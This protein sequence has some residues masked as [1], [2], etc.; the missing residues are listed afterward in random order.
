M[1][2]QNRI[3]SIYNVDAIAAEHSAVTDLVKKSIEQIEAARAKSIDFNINTKTF[4]DYNKKVKEL[5]KSLNVM[6]KATR[7]A[8]AGSTA[9]AKQKEAEAKAQL[10]NTRATTAATKETERQTASAKKAAAAASQNEREYK[11][12]SAAYKV[13]KERAEDLGAKYGVLDKRAKAAAKEAEGLNDK[14]KAIDK[15]I[16]NHQRNVGNYSSALEGVGG[17]IKGLTTNFLALLGVVGVGDFFKGAIDE[18]L[19]MDRNVRLLQNTL[20][21]IGMPEAFDR[22]SA[23]ADKLAKQFGYLDNDDVLKSFQQLITYGKLTEDQMNELLPVIIDFAAATGQGIPEATST[24]IKVLEGNGKALK[25]YGINIKDAKNTT[26]AFGIVMTE[27]AP[28]V[29][30]VGKTFGD[31]AAG[32]LAASQQRFKDL[33]EEIGSGLLPVL[34][35]VLSVLVDIAK[36]AFGAGKAVSEALGGEKSFTAAVLENSDNKDIAFES[37]QVFNT[38]MSIYKEQQKQLADRQKEGKLLDKTQDDLQKDFTT[39]LRARLS[40]RQKVY[41]QLKKSGFREGIMTT[42]ADIRGIERALKEIETVNK[43]IEA[44][45]DPN[46]LFKEGGD[47]KDKKTKAD[48]SAFDILKANIELDKEF[49]ARRLENDKLSYQDRLQALIDYGNDSRRL[50]EEQAKQDLKNSELTAGERIKI[51]NDKNN[52]LIRLSQELADKLAKITARDFK[53]DTSKI[54]S[55]AGNLPKEIQ[56]A[57]DDYKK[58]QDDAIKKHEE[59][60]KEL[61]KNTHEAIKELASELQGLFFDI[62]T[63]AIER[64]K[65]AVQDQIDLLEAQKQKDIEVANQTITNAQERADA[66]AVIEARASAKRQQLELKQRQLDQQKAKFEKARLVAEIVQTT[67]LAVVKALTQADKLGPGAIALAAVIGALG[68]VQIARVLAQPIP[69][70]KDGT[71]NHPGGL[72]VVGDGGRSEGVILP[73]GSVYKTPATDTVVNLPKGSKVVPDYADMKKPAVYVD[74]VDTT[75]ELRKGFGQVV[76]AVRRI[77]QPIIQAEKAWTVAH[78]QGSNFRNYLNR[79]L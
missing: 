57:L 10:A 23:S 6:D 59:A 22:I 38:Q 39:K 35:S 17:K 71:E 58:A 14:L 49:D 31:S 8:I 54:G 47:K 16:G 28:K 13:A 20:K 34:N 44:T 60:L 53:V 66:I 24:V 12:L 79:A 69:R 40:E 1:A 30:G 46:K 68:A 37:N 32:G 36:G 74:S 78:R 64:Q 56:K 27:L 41:D 61:K 43:K 2:S 70:Y 72:A 55:A 52:A 11:K 5:E 77:P 3:D 33:K 19:G 42:L 4:D 15:T 25:E 26:E 51:E 7:D 50:I 63:N 29:A 9:L 65:N 48:T 73:D 67:S 75:Q 62:F 76:N 21:N 45:T 18:F